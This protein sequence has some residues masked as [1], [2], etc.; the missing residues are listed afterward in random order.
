MRNYFVMWAALGVFIGSNFL[1]NHNADDLPLPA[2][3]LP[4]PNTPLTAGAPAL[5]DWAAHQV[6][7]SVNWYVPFLA[8]TVAIDTLS[9]HE[10]SAFCL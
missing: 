7:E 2:T 8:S 6:Q 1:V 4:A 5:Y 3:A 9:S 10:F